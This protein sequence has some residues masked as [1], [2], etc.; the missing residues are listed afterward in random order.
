MGVKRQ[1]QVRLA[2]ETDYPAAER[3]ESELCKAQRVCVAQ[4]MAPYERLDYYH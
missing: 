1:Y 2:T 3:S 4:R